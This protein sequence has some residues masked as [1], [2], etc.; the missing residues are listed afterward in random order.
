MSAPA[1]PPRRSRLCAWA[2]VVLVVVGC[3]WCWADE[4]ARAAIERDDI[5]LSSVALDVEFVDETPNHRLIAKDSQEN[6]RGGIGVQ[7]AK[8]LE[9]A[10]DSIISENDFPASGF[11]VETPSGNDSLI[12]SFADPPL[13]NATL[14]FRL[15]AQA[16]SVEYGNATLALNAH[17]L[18]WSMDVRRQ[19]ESLPSPRSFHL[20]LAIGS[21]SN[22]SSA[23][24]ALD[25]RE[26]LT[27][28]P[29]RYFA[30]QDQGERDLRADFSFPTFAFR[31]T[32]GPQR[33][34][35]VDAFVASTLEMAE[36]CVDSPTCAQAELGDAVAYILVS[37]VDAFG[38][39]EEDNGTAS[40]SAKL[41][42]DPSASAEFDGD[43]G[44]KSQSDDDDDAGAIVIVV[45]TTVV[46]VVLCGTALLLI[47]AVAA[48][49]WIH[50]I[51]YKEPYMMLDK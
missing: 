20:I 39:F 1:V 10:N 3:S 46:P 32:G 35:S 24:F 15:Y 18:K 45:V 5:L 41:F 11:A 17:T 25:R 28:P 34:I 4:H 48:R 6:R 42:Y 51:T 38:S 22:D 43:S 26:T 12:F 19:V 47:L 16:A 30:L 23:P 49:V 40:A 2:A 8:W 31:S 7:F 9:T 33:Q 50:T 37:F 13:E 14:T 27:D 21:A 44:R 36:A 29:Q